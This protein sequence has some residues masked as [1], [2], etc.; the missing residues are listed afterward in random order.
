MDGW[1]TGAFW[2]GFRECLRN[3]MAI[4]WMDLFRQRVGASPRGAAGATVLEGSGLGGW[5]PRTWIRG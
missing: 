2:L 1:N 3:P 5:A 4:F